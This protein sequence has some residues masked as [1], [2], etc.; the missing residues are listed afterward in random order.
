M[1]RNDEAY[2]S[3]AQEHAWAEQQ[4]PWLVNET[5]ERHLSARLH[6]HMHDCEVCRTDFQRQQQ[7]RRL[8]TSEPKVDYAP[9][10]SL[11]RLQQAIDQ[12]S[13]HVRLRRYYSRLARWR[14]PSINIW[15]GI[16]G[17]QAITVLVLAVVIGSLQ[18]D[19]SSTV[20]SQ[21]ANYQTLSSSDGTLNEAHL[22]VVFNEQ[23]SL[24]NIRQLLEPIDAVIASGPSEQGVFRVRVGQSD[25]QEQADW[26]QAQPG[27]IF[28][29]ISGELSDGEHR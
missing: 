26:L 10:Q 13:L 17:A 25:I 4:M 27:V 8:L 23:L 22:Q 9:Q 1:S 5:L 2:L 15:Q 20:D 24:A 29:A 16:I 19:T 12:P 6:R 14:F 28:V 11:R 21:A 7:L 18:L 3:R